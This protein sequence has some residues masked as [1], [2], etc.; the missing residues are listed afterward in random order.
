MVLKDSFYR[1]KNIVQDDNGTYA[2]NVEILPGHPIYSGHFPGKPVVPGVCTLTI[3]KEC[4]GEIYGRAI[5]FVSIKECKYIS[6]LL[7]EKKIAIT[8]NATVEDSV[9]L[10]ATAIKDEEY[11]PVLKLRATIK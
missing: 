7:P 9:K 10:R 8:I 5:E 1:I 11:Q 6:A 3:I 4:L 2:I